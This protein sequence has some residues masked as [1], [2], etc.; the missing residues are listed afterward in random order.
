MFK[1]IKKFLKKQILEEGNTADLI[2][3][4]AKDIST[5][6]ISKYIAYLW[7]YKGIRH[8]GYIFTN[9]KGASRYIIY[10][11]HHAT[12]DA[13]YYFN[14]RCPAMIEEEIIEVCNNTAYSNLEW[15]STSYNGGIPVIVPANVDVNKYN[16]D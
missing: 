15:T 3:I 10:Q 13:L 9:N 7:I 14:D 6:M 8:L 1:F 4:S 11:Y 12:Q 16:E 5:S 2:E